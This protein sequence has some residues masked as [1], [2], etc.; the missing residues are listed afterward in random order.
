M[1]TIEL[2]DVRKS[3]GAVRAV[4]DL[5]LAVSPGEIVA[6]LGP[7]GAGKTTTI[8]MILGLT[9]PTSGSVT[10]FGASPRQAVQA[11]RIGALMQTGGLLRDLTVRET[12]R[13][14]AALQR[15]TERVDDIM[16]RTRL[17]E[18]AGR[19]VSK[20]SGGE[21]QRIK[22]ALALLTDPEL[23]ILDEPTTGMDVGAR[24]EFWATMS[25]EA[26]AG[27]TILFATHY[28][29][30]A[31]DFAQRVVLIGH[32]R[33]LADGPVAQVQAMTSGREVQASFTTLDN[34]RIAAI[35]SLPGVSV[36]ETNGTR[37]TITSSDSDEVARYLLANGAFDL[38]ISA[39]TL[40]SAFLT[41]TKDPS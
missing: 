15:T 6:F 33:L 17:T 1:N 19:K 7:N 18:L 14:I 4:D 34:A 20:C 23:L 16:A 2:R 11:G 10:V 13:A 32:G 39:P 38:V 27:R 36:V 35:S 9:Q 3:F 12:I 5:S 22:F 24:R 37:A 40:E 25:Q 28:L 26:H 41:L 21:Q 8:D 31:Q 29:E 30:E